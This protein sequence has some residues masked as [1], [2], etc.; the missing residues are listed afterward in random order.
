[1]K[2]AKFGIFVT[3]IG[4]VRIVIQKREIK[5]RQIICVGSLID[6]MW[7][8]GNVGHFQDYTFFVVVRSI[9]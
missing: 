1:M 2:I 6:C 3:S 8:A 9:D 7:I 5:N 4:E